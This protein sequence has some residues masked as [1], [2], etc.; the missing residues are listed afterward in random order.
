MTM[1]KENACEGAQ[2]VASVDWDALAGQMEAMRKLLHRENV[3][4]KGSRET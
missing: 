2:G 1:D 3:A 4:G